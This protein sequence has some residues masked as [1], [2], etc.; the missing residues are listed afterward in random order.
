M[1]Q[2]NPSPAYMDASNQWHDTAL[3][4]LLRVIDTV[5]ATLDPGNNTPDRKVSLIG[6]PILVMVASVELE[7]TA[8]TDRKKLAIDPV[9]LAQPP[10]VPS[11]PVRI[12]DITRPNDGVF[13]IFKPGATPDQSK[14]APVSI[15]AAQHA[16][17]N[18]LTEGVAYNSQT[19]APVNHPFVLNQVNVIAVQPDT[20]Q[21]A[22]LL[23]DIRGDIYATA[24]VLPRKSI[25]LPKDFLDGALDNMEPVFAVGPVFTASTAT[26][27]LQALFPPPQVQGYD[28]SFSPGTGDP[29]NDLGMPPAPPLGDL[30]STRVKLDEGWVRL[31]KRNA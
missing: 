18:G 27:S 20:P 11:I 22:I 25:T 28:V 12:G 21:Q 19:G 24:G 31:K 9:A 17:L 5:R 23:T 6:E 15:D 29:A 3:T 1:A 26:G 13:G 4:A 14:F 30:P 16:I 8:E 7:T 2:K 10:T